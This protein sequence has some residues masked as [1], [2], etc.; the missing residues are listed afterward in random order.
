GQQHAASIVHA[1]QNSPEWERTLII[2]T[3]DENGGFWDHVRPPTN[4]GA[5]GEGNRIPA[6]IIS[7]FAKRGFIDHE[8]Y[9]TLSILKT[10]EQRYDRRSVNALDAKASSL[11]NS[12]HTRADASLG[13][14]YLE[15]DG[16][17]PGKSVLIVLG[18]QACDTIDI[19]GTAT[20]VRVRMRGR[21]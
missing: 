9:N 6:L 3:Y 13:V 4:N 16:E 12:L 18:T 17:N 21:E 2:L 20:G 10:I 1:I 7:P 5:W 15:R 11:T 14:A 19:S 8:E